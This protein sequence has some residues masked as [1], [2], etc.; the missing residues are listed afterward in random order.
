MTSITLP[1][2]VWGHPAREPGD[3]PVRAQWQTHTGLPTEPDPVEITILRR[4]RLF[5]GQIVSRGPDTHMGGQLMTTHDLRLVPDSYC[6][7]DGRFTLPSDVDVHVTVTPLAGDHMFVGSVHPHFGHTVL[8]GLARVWAWQDFAARH[9]DGRALV[10]EPNLPDFAWELLRRAG[11]PRDRIMLLDRPLEVERLHLPSP[12]GRTHRWYA[13]P[14]VE[15]WQ[16]IGASIE[17][18][19]PKA[20]QPSSDRIYLTR[21]TNRNRA[22]ANEEQIERAFASAG[23]AV[24]NPSTMPLA[25]QLKLVRQAHCLAGCAGSQMYL[26][27]FQPPGG[28]TF[29]LAPDN[30]IYADD[31]LIAAALGRQLSLAFG[32][33]IRYRDPDATWSVDEAAVEALVADA[34]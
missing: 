4:G 14:L 19:G 10:Y 9:P 33:S 2:I 13:R 30:F 17:T 7:M 16:S 15:T 29:V 20:E 5:P 21:R 27:A 31:A 11:V 24:A 8:E 32:T 12:A 3:A 28:R 23:F 6:G 1:S 25:D 34:R 18:E 22:L 26:A